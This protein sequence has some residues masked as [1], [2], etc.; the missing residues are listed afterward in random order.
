[1]LGVI[2]LLLV[3]TN[4]HPHDWDE[5]RWEIDIKLMKDASFN[6]V[7]L[8]HLCWDSFESSDG[9]YNFKWFD[10]VVDRFWEANIKVVLDIATRP[11]PVWLHKKHPSI[12]ITDLYGQMQESHTRYMEDVGNPLFQKYAYRFAKAITERY[13]S[14]PALL[15]FGLCNELGAGFVSYSE[16]VKQRFIEWLQSKYGDIDTLNKAW[17]SQRWSRRLSCFREV[18][19][20]ASAITNASPERTLDLCRFYSDEII[21]YMSGLKQIVHKAA[22]QV[23][24]STNHWAENRE[25]GFDYLK[26]YED[27]I[28]IPGTG[29]YPGVNPEDH[30][31]VIGTCML[32]DHRI[33]ETGAPIWCLE[34][35]TGTFGGYGCPKGAMRMYAYLALIYRSQAIVAWTWRSM[36]GGEEQY[37]FGLLDHDG[38]TGR[39]YF[40]FKQIA[41]EFKRLEQYDLPRRITPDVA[42]AYSFES[43]KVS[44]SN[45]SYYK[46]DY[47]D[48]LLNTYKPLFKL[49]MDCN[50]I[51]LRKIKNEYKLILIP[52]HCLMD[53]KSAETVKNFIMSGGTVV[54]TAYSAKVNEH[55]QVFS[56][57]QPG[58]LNEVFG[59]RANAFERTRTHIG[60]TNEGGIEKHDL[61]ITRQ[62]PGIS[63]NDVEYKV[64]IDYY[65]VLEPTTATSWAYFT[66][67]DENRMAISMNMY[68]KGMAIY[69][70]TPAQEEIM[71]ALMDLLCAGMGIEKGPKTPPS[72]V[73]RRISKDIA[74]Y[75][76]TTSQICEIETSCSAKSLI[77]NNIYHGN[78]R[79]DPYGADVIAFSSPG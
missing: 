19:L 21:Q 24:E 4:Y 58:L 75:V 54:M 14:H 17:A 61:G 6:I 47:Y 30:N 16:G 3:G 49:N 70:A 68:G 41:E 73:A 15:A 79:L 33:A 69:L 2:N 23:R 72:V 27:L 29:F 67:L 76:N 31:A 22:P 51:D 48:Q 65:E 45:K 46:T 10:R 50:I 34:F 20:P 9:V 62:R 26:A 42:I 18:V 39:K 35:Q 5:S 13:A 44:M 66:H 7:R 8:G 78:I 60:S 56:I 25:I 77:T 32:M 43:F 12:N 28:D 64:D 40:E 36:I 74:L 37:L 59:I 71:H 53:D 52:G 63:F 1:M 38:V 11:A 55:N 57:P